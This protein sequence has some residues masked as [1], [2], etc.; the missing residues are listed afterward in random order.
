MHGTKQEL[1]SR[2]YRLVRCDPWINIFSV[3]SG[4]KL[5]GEAFSS[6]PSDTFDVNIFPDGYVLGHW[7]W[8]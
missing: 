4:N 5:V 6:Y 8:R 3:F 2:G 7:D 1:E